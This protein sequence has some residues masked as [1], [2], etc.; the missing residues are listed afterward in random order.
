MVFRLL[1]LVL[2]V[3]LAAPAVAQPA[4]RAGQSGRETPRSTVLQNG[5]DHFDKAFYDLTPKGR[6]DEAASEFAAAVAAFD[7]ELTTNPSSAEAHRYL[8]RIYAARRN[9][10]K[11]AGHYDKLAA[12]EPFNVDACVLSALAWLDAKNPAEAR[13][14]LVDATERTSDPRVLA[15]LDGYLAKVDALKR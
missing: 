11:A 5:I 4:G 14:R 13:R 7:R 6:H 12:I 15:Q 10:Q 3:A 8:G 2:I 9:F 1:P